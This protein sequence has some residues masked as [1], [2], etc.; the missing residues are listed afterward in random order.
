MSRG[1]PWT[2][3]RSW[4][5]RVVNA[6]DREAPVACNNTLPVGRQTYGIADW[7]VSGQIGLVMGGFSGAG[8]GSPE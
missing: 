6:C 4:T 3:A 7:R 8:S 5:G 2:S 1:G